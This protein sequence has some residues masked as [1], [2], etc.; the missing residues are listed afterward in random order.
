M[1]NGALLKL[2]L[3]VAVGIG[4]WDVEGNGAAGRG[5][6]V[7]P[8]FPGGWWERHGGTQGEISEARGP[9][10]AELSSGAGGNLE[11]WKRGKS[12]IVEGEGVT[13]IKR[14]GDAVPTDPKFLIGQPGD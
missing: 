1:T 4:W 3:E 6:I 9:G 2:Q 12:E 10:D 11:I 7:A 13:P 8:V 5:K 14:M